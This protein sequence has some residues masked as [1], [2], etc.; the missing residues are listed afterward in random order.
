MSPIGGGSTHLLELVS[1]DAVWCAWS[2]QVIVGGGDLT[3]YWRR[4]HSYISKLVLGRGREVGLSHGIR[5]TSSKT[6]PCIEHNTRVGRRHR[7]AN[8]VFATS[9]S[10]R[11]VRL[12]ENS[13]RRGRP[14][15]PPLASSLRRATQ[16][17]GVWRAFGCV[18]CVRLCRVV[19]VVIGWR[20]AMHLRNIVLGR[21]LHVRLHHHHHHH[22]PI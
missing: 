14:A 1:A 10:D 16:N 11:H 4:V 18:A 5:T 2:T 20:T 6:K 3:L 7:M 22:H 9:R 17:G 19:A 21:D 15:P 12:R 8:C 13:A